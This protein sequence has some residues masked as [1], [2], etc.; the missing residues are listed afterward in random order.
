MIR[1]IGGSRA[2]A[3]PGLPS[4]KGVDISRANPS[5]HGIYEIPVLPFHRA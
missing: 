5:N 2:Y 3:Y 4:I 1:E